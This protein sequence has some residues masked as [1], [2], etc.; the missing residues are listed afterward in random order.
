VRVISNIRMSRRLF[1]AFGLVVALL[2]LLAGVAL[3]AMS[4]LQAATE[5]LART[6]VVALE[7]LGEVD[8]RVQMNGRIAT[9][10]VWE[11]EGDVGQQEELAAAFAD[12][13]AVIG[14]ELAAM[15]ELELSDDVRRELES[16]VPLREAYV[17]AAEAA[18]SRA[19][20]ESRR[21]SGDHSASQALYTQRLLPAADGLTEA[22]EGLTTAIGVAA[23]KAEAHANDAAAPGRLL[24]LVVGALALLVAAG[25]ALLVTR[26]IVG[27]LRRLEETTAKAAEGD[28]TVS[29]GSQARDE[30]GQVSRGLD[31]MLAATREMVAKVIDSVDAQ[32][33][34]SAEMRAAAEQTG[35]AVG[36]I[37]TTVEQVAQG[38]SQQAQSTERIAGTV[39][40]M[41]EG[42]AQVASGGQTAAGVADETARAAEGG[43]ETVTAAT[44]AMARIQESVA[45]V[46]D[47][48]SAL[49]ERS[50]AIGDI[51]DTIGQIADQT[52]LLALNAAIE[53]A[54]AGEQ[55][56]GFAVVA[57][58][59]RKLAESTQDQA[60]SIAE[61]I[62]DI[63][64]ETGRAIEAMEVGRREVG[65]GAERVGA[66]GEAFDAIQRQVGV[67]SSEVAQVA[68]AAQQLD[69]GAR[70]VQEGVAGIASVSEENAAATE[71]VS[72]STQETSAA[73]HQ[74]SGSAQQLAAGAEELQ[75][76]V[77]R[78]TV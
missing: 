24:I 39:D 46:G 29:L 16:T 31:A 37:A 73:S 38:A 67:L 34:T 25:L 65:E 47:V 64:R 45:G 36:Q 56:R 20:A 70:A 9:Q 68:A 35:V 27:P 76:L 23:D 61:I 17:A 13:K 53:A 11:A 22:L 3:N 50:R 57:E 2:A 59:V 28:L 30:I 66:A 54:R 19:L 42:I 69:A 32:R 52:N 51:V 75:A 58:E 44:D 72:A 48:V 4:S 26:S 15:A 77:G 8:V 43:V 7:H 62:G 12:N 78:F 49:G 63:Q 18:M 74:V 6:D 71:Q 5:E 55:G 41:A 40:E 14:S 10:V 33:R 1:G 60:G 21:G